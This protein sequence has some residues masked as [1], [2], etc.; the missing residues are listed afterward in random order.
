MIAA[1]AL[2]VIALFFVGRMFFGSSGTTSPPTANKP[3]PR[4]ATTIQQAGVGKPDE[5]VDEDLVTYTEV[6]YD[7]PAFDGADV[8]RNIFAYYVRP[9]ATTNA[10]SSAVVPTPPPATPTPTPPLTLVS[11][12]PQ[13]VYARTSNFTLQVSG[14]KFTPATRVFVDGQE[15]QTQFKSPQQLSATVSASVIAAPGSRQII[16]RTPDNQL[17]SNTATI[18]VM[19]PPVPTFTYVGFLNRKRFNTAVLRDQKGE[20]YSVQANDTV[21]RRFLV[22]E[23]SERGV[24]LV[25]KELNI[26]HTLPLLDPRATTSGP[27]R[28][29]IGSI[30][31]PPPPR[32]EDEDADEEP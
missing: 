6:V 14:D 32:S 31:P 12:A 24:S 9:V 19:Q 20:L 27:A 29:S 15:M 1:M 10:N 3:R 21:E 13:S 17:Y 2:G 28:P 16:V 5:A 26:K 11:L 7:R 4:A 8:G 18:N 23:V 30:Q 22:T 25:D